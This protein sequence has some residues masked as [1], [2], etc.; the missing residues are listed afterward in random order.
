[1]TL[2][3]AILL[4]GLILGLLAGVPVAMS[5]PHPTRIAFVDT[6]NTGRSVA[7]EALADDIIDKSHLNAQVIS[8]AVN[9]NP[10]NTHPEANFVDLLH[11]RGM[12]ITSHTA[13]Q[14]GA[15][16]AAFSDVILTMTEAHKAWILTHFPEDRGKVFTLGEYA[17]GTRQEVLDPFGKSMDFYKVVLGQLDQMVGAAVTKAAARP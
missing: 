17:T 9:L 8:R 5:A 13:A 16:E 11:G 14:F 2:T 3:H 7:A 4:P 12:N 10:F 6:G 1:M 15:Q